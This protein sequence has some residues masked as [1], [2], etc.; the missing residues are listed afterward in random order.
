MYV[1]TQGNSVD[2][3]VL[4]LDCAGGFMIVVLAKILKTLYLK[5]EFYVWK[6][7]CNTA[8]EKR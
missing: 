1:K 4:C 8:L 7:H 5:G 3:N 6:L 2:E